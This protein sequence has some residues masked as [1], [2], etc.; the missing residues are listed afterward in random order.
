MPIFRATRAVA[1]PDG[2]LLSFA[3][4]G[5]PN[6][7]PVVALHGGIHAHPIWRLADDAAR[8]RGVRLIAPDRPGF[9]TS[10]LHPTRRVVD[11]PTDLAALAEALMLDDFSVVTVGGGAVYGLAAAQCLGSRVRRLGLVAPAEPEPD[12]GTVRRLGA[13]MRADVGAAGEALLADRPRDRQVFAE[14]A[15]W[16]AYESSLRL[17]F[18]DPDATVIDARLRA[19]AWRRSSPSIPTVTHV[20]EGSAYGWLADLDLVLRWLA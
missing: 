2:R 18:A 6:G 19:L 11:D 16:A 1:L 3:L 9:G 17:A 4:Y 20:W 15:G 12:P 5:D 13:E 14:D 7:A 8:G 10:T